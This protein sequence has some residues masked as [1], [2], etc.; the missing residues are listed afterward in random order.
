MILNNHLWDDHR[1]IKVQSSTKADW[2]K[3]DSAII[4]QCILMQIKACLLEVNE[5]DD[6]KMILIIDLSKGSFPPW[7][8]AL[9]IAKFFVEVKQLLKSGLAFTLIYTVTETQKT[10]INRILMMYTPARP[11]HMVESK[12]EIRQKINEY[13]GSVSA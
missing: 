3:P 12:D 7:M 8:E 5:S 6:Q 11:V 13:K 4:T 2:S 1:I 10:W 9:K